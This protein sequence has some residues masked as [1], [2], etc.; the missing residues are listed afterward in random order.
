MGVGSRRS[1]TTKKSVSYLIESLLVIQ[2]NPSPLVDIYGFI[3]AGMTV[4]F[5]SSSTWNFGEGGWWQKNSRCTQALIFVRRYCYVSFYLHTTPSRKTIWT[6]WETGDWSVFFICLLFFRLFL[7]FV[8]CLLWLLRPARFVFMEYECL[9]FW[10][11]WIIEGNWSSC[12]A[13]CS[14]LV[15]TKQMFWIAHKEVGTDNVIIWNGPCMWTT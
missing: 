15:D 5:T 3:H 9:L 1:S 2:L 11:S 12:N 4:G 10:V 6:T 13:W 8:S 14:E 7:C